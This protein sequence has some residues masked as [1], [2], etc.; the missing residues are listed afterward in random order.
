MS[1]SMTLYPLLSISST[2]EDPSSHELKSVDWDVKNESLQ[3]P[4]R[5]YQ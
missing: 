1:L 3:K 2:Q 4:M 5:T